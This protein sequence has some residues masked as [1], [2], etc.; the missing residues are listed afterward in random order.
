MNSDPDVAAL[1][2]L[3]V[4]VEDAA[5]QA[6]WGRSRSSAAAAAGWA[7]QALQIGGGPSLVQAVADQAPKAVVLDLPSRAPALSTMLAP[8]AGRAPCGVLAVLADADDELLLKLL[9]AGVSHVCPT[10]DADGLAAQ[11]QIAA[12]Q[13]KH[14]QALQAAA[15]RLQ[16]QL[17]ERKAI[18]R[19]KGLLMSARGFDEDEA[20]RLLRNAAMH[21]HLRLVDV[22][23]SVIDA[24]RWAEALNRAGQLR[25]LSQR[26]VALAAQRL[27]QIDGARERLAAAVERAQANIEHLAALPLQGDDALQR[28]AVARAWSALQATL[29][30]TPSAAQVLTLDQ[31]AQALLDAAE[32][33]TA[34]LE[35]HAA[36][37]AL[38]L[39]NLCGRQRMRAQ[40][41]AKQAWLH[42]LLPAAERSANDSAMRQGIAEFE[43][44]LLQIEAAPLSSPEIRQAL[45][46]TREQWPVL[47]RCLYADDAA[48]AARLAHSSEAL[49]DTL[50]RL[51]ASCEHSLQ[52]LMA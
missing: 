46:T 6:A 1:V 37:P 45:A 50:D 16:A 28:E 41:L 19:A 39:I 10:L 18:D 40:R 11:L 36:R 51:T 27:A 43:A 3:L 34:S 47:L 33:L 14:R 44:T 12:A 20:F 42:A 2:P 30:G 17:V 22:A 31:R 24:A 49:L 52:V 32:A 25:M 15:D 13:F 29:R 35:Q 26:G 23:Q 9:E 21:A 48:E 38:G 8:W 4:V 5:A 7:L